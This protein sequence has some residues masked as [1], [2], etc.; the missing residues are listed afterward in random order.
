MAPDGSD[1]QVALFAKSGLS[2]QP[3]AAFFRTR[4]LA[5]QDPQPDNKNIIFIWLYN[6]LKSSSSQNNDH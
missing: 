4:D 3:T 5:C 1:R 2:S 6:E